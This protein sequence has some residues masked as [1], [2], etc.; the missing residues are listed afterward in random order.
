MALLKLL[1]RSAGTG[2][3]A[4][5][6]GL[7]PEQLLRGV[8]VGGGGHA[9]LLQLFFLAT[10]ELGFEIVHRGGGPALWGGA[11]L[12]SLF[13]GRPRRG[14]AFDDLHVE[15]IAD[16]VFLKALHHLFKHLKT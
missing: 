11:L 5:Y 12:G 4:P 14:D 8:A 7:T 2:I 16:R 10:L 6:L 3:I 9:G 15:Q 1:P 13:G